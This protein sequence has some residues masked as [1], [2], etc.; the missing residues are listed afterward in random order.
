MRFRSCQHNF[1]HCASGAAA[2]EFAM[3]F[4]TFISL[5]LGIVE[6]GRALFLRNQLAFAADIAIRHVLLNPPTTN[7]DLNRID[8]IIRES[9]K[10]DH[11]FLEIERALPDASG[12]MP[13]SIRYP[14]TLLVPNLVQNSIILSINRQIQLPLRQ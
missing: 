3:V 5:L 6:F 12:L 1:Y 8:E 7:S 2:I 13:I 4:L 11:S 14:A 10:F 9:I